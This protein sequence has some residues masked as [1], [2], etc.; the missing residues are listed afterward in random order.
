M[1][2]KHGPAII[3]NSGHSIF[4][5]LITYRLG[6]KNV[7]TVASLEIKLGQTG[8]QLGP[9]IALTWH[10]KVDNPQTCASD[11]VDSNL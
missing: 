4:K 5:L 11:H 3:Q 9:N 7:L 6:L 8:S 1:I 10:H 2:N